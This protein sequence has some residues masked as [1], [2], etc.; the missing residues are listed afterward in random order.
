MLEENLVELANKVIKQKAEEQTIEVKSAN[1]G[2]PKRLYDTL[3][4]FSNQDSG[5]ILLF[6]IDET[7]NFKI[8]GVYDLQ[9]LQK[10]V[11]EQCLQME[12]PVRAVFTF[13]Q[14]DGLNICSAEIPG[15]DLSERPCYYKGIGKVKGS[16]IRVG[17]ADLPMTDYELYSFE[18]FRK[19]LHDDERLVER[20]NIKSLDLPSVE[21]YVLEKRIDRPK[22]A[23][24]PIEIAYE[25]LNILRDGVPTMASLMNFG[26]YPQG[27]FPQ[28]GITAIVVPGTQI[29]DTDDND[30]RFLDNKRI[31]GNLSS[32]LLEATAFCLRN[33]KTKTII[34]KKTGQRKDQT[35]YPITAIREAVLNALV[36]RDYS[37]YTEG[38]PIQIIF[39][40]NRLEIHSPGSLYGRMTV[41]QLGVAKPDLRNPALA[42]MAEALTDAE[43]RYSGIPTMRK[44]MKEFNLPEP[45]FENRRNEFVVTFCNYNINKEEQL[46]SIRTDKN[47][48]IEEKILSFCKEP[49]TRTEIAAY[50]GK[51]T[52]FY[53]TN[54]YIMPLIREGKLQ[55]TIPDKPKSR[56]QK[57]YTIK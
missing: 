36:H 41:E 18:A 17:D 43:N 20:A 10:K 12:P 26:I 23:Q 16:Y 47:Y 39:F 37:I 14:I 53:I 31:E 29:G 19:H 13:A 34:D 54:K 7:Q 35:E 1:N 3:S 22:F 50:L 46:Y 25:M 27:Y 8:V 55:Q 56:N 2:C 5:G 52:V 42:V 40:T 28:L 38:T 6:G 33:M 45:I 49:K 57:Y 51:K 32:M 4:S 15:I 11:T 44:E 9:D 21:K 24:L 48:S 30:V